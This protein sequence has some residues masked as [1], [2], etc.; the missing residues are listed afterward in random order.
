MNLE[1][2]LYS[3]I[4]AKKGNNELALFYFR[5]EWQILLGNTASCVLLGESAGEIESDWLASPH[6]CADQIASKMGI[7]FY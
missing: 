5:G 7:S 6:E 1:S 4:A 3:L 2:K